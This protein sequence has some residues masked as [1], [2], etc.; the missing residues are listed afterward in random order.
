MKF[1]AA[2]RHE[3]NRSDLVIGLVFF[4]FSVFLYF[5]ARSRDARINAPLEVARAVSASCTDAGPFR[6]RASKAI[7]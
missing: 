3:R 7:S 6:Y 4:C 2:M 5:C 1:G